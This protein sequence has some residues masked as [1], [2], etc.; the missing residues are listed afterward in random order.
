VEAAV[1]IAPK[2]WSSESEPLVVTLPMMPLAPKTDVTVPLPPTAG[3]EVGMIFPF[4]STARNDPAG[5]PSDGIQP[6][7]TVRRLVEALARFT[8]LVKVDDAEK[9]LFPENVLLSAKRVDDAAVIVIA[10]E[11]SK[12]T[13]LMARGVVS[14]VAVPAFPVIEPV[15]AFAKVSLPEKALLSDNKVEL[16]APANEVR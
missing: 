7:P 15:I 6:V 3:V 12:F 1:Q 4:G 9:R 8:T 14:F 5:M 11:P 16:A 10:A 2:V 13:L